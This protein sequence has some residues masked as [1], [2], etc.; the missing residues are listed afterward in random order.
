MAKNNGNYK[1]IGFILTAAVLFASIVG[2]WTVYG[3]D[4][5]DN[6]EDI[7]KLED[8]GCNPA[9]KAAF[10]IALIEKDIETIQKS[11]NQMRTEQK[12]GFREILSRLQK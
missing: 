12:A 9:N 4:I 2:T 11:Q 3:E 8:D 7:T 6:T 10:N 5:K 1:L